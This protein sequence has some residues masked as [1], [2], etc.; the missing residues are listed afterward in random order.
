MRIRSRLATGLALLSLQACST[1]P[2]PDLSGIFDAASLPAMQWDHRP[3]AAE[4]TSRS[5]LAVAD[6]DTVL[7]QSVPGDIATWCPGYEK[8]SRNDRRA[9]WVGLM[10]T[11]AKYESGFNPA[12]SGGGGRYIGLMQIA[13]QT[14]RQYGC[15][16]T[17]SK[18]LKD[19]GA[20]LECAVEIMA[21]QVGRDGVV[22]GKGN[23]GV[24]R[25]WMPLRK[26]SNR[27][28]MAKWTSAQSYCKG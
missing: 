8:A 17:S 28:A 12:A 18:G 20:N 9:F 21:V 24:G 27:A 25:D 5:L 1:I 23:R 7:A 2:V 14:A 4:W 11:I 15:A 16:A 22:A 26:A 19:G 6:K 3:E 10:S 13:P